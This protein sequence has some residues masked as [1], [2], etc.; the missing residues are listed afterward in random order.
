MV[1]SES[2]AVASPRPAREPLLHPCGAGWEGE[3]RGERERHARP[4]RRCRLPGVCCFPLPARTPPATSLGVGLGGGGWG[5]S[6]RPHPHPTRLRP[7]RRPRLPSFPH[8]PAGPHVVGPPVASRGL[9]GVTG[10]RLPV[11]GAARLPPSPPAAGP[12]PGLPR[13]VAGR[14]L[15]WAC[16]AVARHLPTPALRASGLSPT[17]APQP[18]LLRLSARFSRPLA[19][20]LPLSCVPLPAWHHASRWSPFP[21]ALGGGG[22]EGCLGTRV[23][24]RGAPR[25]T[26]EES[27]TGFPG[28]GPG[29]ARWG[30]RGEESSAPL[31]GERGTCGG[32]SSG[33]GGDPPGAVGPVHSEA[34]MRHG[35]AA[36]R[37]AGGRGCVGDAVVLVVD[38]GA[39]ARGARRAPRP[40]PPFQV[41]SASR[42]GGLKTPGGVARPPW[43]RGGRARGESGGASR[44]PQTPPSP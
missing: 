33:V 15:L 42:R 17:P 8:R 16:R 13:P 10:W 32:W 6:A 7:W 20:P 1:G 38:V 21:S 4:G 44:L 29:C 14:P 5:R 18:R 22:G 41:P 40:P 37:P 24:V 31:R 9:C 3:K 19:R 36:P 23:R 43:G 30:G 12:G 39:V 34:P 25:W 27:G 2:G 26:G 28:R 11:A 35:P